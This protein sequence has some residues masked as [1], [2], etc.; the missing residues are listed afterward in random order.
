MKLSAGLA[1]LALA[2]LGSMAVAQDSELIY[3]GGTT[4]ARIRGPGQYNSI[5][6][7]AKEI[8]KALNDC[9]SGK[10]T[11]HP[12]TSVK[13]KDG[14]WTIYAWDKPVLSVQPEEA[15]A[16]GVDQKKLAEMWK[17]ALHK[18][19]KNAT[20]V[21]KM[22]DPFGGYTYDKPRTPKTEGAQP[23]P[24]VRESSTPE[25]VAQA[26]GTPG[27]TPGSRSVGGATGPVDLLSVLATFNQV[28]AMTE[29]E[30]AMQR[31][32]LAA[33]LV[34]Q[35]RGGK[36]VPDIGAGA[37][38][39]P[40][41]KPGSTEITQPPPKPAAITETTEKPVPKPASTAT[42]EPPQPA[43]AAAAA[44]T[45]NI[46]IKQR[47][48]KKFGLADKP[49]RLMKRQGHPDAAAIKGL[50]TQARDAFFAD[51]FIESEQAL[52]RALQMM[53]VQPE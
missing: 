42:T 37:S 4:V 26:T 39:T 30:Y 19:L 28:R 52:D 32:Q 36:G 43:G 10:D 27:V 45:A 51:R 33:N 18:G 12:K 44:G 11:N 7:R 9:I 21:S 13:K 17:S 15:K 22:E 1:A 50:L 23:E 8:N 5:Y 41:V 24:T 35:L 14:L 2:T 25:R 31:E 20:P 29:A 38:P 53:G 16:N 6:E 34:G 3:C 47:I 48:D 40:G 49:F 46:E